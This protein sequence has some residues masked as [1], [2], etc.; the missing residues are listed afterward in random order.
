MKLNID[1]DAGII[2]D[3][4]G[5]DI[6]LYSDEGFELLS[7][8]WVKSGWNQ[9]Y[10]YGF[11]WA[12]MPIIQMPEDM[13]RFQEVVWQ[14][15]PDVIIE[16]G[17]A[18]GGSLVYSA[19]LLHLMRKG[20]V[21]GIDIDIRP[22]NRAK[23]QT[24]PLAGRIHLIEGSSTSEDVLHKVRAHIQPDEIVLVVLDSDHSYAHVMA[25]LETYSD[26]VSPG[27]YIIAT[28]GVMQDLEDVPRGKKG[29]KKDNP[30]QA[31]RDFAEKNENFVLEQPK[32]PFNESTLSKNITHWPDAWLK[33]VK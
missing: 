28:D 2:T 19:S 15:R 4:D 9:K 5:K 30:A 23:I 31:A 6:K 21:V 22:Q 10:S 1:T 12:G 32:W 8:L 26:F 27:S 24:H 7:H 20:K 17:V 13:I 25:E 14:L 33:R 11:S 3:E 18:H 29:W 16:T